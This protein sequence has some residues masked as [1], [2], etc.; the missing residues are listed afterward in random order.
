MKTKSMIIINKINKNV[1]INKLL[2]NKI[3]LEHKVLR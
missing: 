1:I 3:L 2:Y